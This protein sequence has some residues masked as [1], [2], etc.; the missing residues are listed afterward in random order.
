MGKLGQENWG[1]GISELAFVHYSF[2]ATPGADVPLLFPLIP[3]EHGAPGWLVGMACFNFI[4]L[5]F[6]LRVMGG[7]D[8][9]GEELRSGKTTLWL[10]MAPGSNDRRGFAS[11]RL[12]LPRELGLL[13][14]LK[15]GLLQQ[16]LGHH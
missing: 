6:M 14:R 7:G 2:C 3:S 10:L 5:G 12:V 1:Q 11:L 15:F 16:D 8:V 9:T 13:S 4:S